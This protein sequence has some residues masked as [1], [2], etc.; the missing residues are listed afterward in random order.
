MAH[1]SRLEIRANDPKDSDVRW[2]CIFK[3]NYVLCGQ[4]FIGIVEGAFLGDLENE[5][6]FAGLRVSPDE[7][8]SLQQNTSTKYCRFY[9]VHSSI[10]LLGGW[11][12]NKRAER[13]GLTIVCE[14]AGCLLPKCV[15]LVDKI[16][17]AAEAD[18]KQTGALLSADEKSRVTSESV[19]EAARLLVNAVMKR[20]LVAEAAALTSARAVEVSEAEASKR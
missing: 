10:K 2:L 3:D 14:T 15:T 9:R 13:H 12:V 18:A 19:I 8:M 1:K 4:W 6:D 20:A 5:G 11:E 16:R 7:Q 17:A